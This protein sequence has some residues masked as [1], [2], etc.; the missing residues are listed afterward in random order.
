[1][2]A[3][4]FRLRQPKDSS[5]ESVFGNWVSLGPLPG[6]NTTTSSDH[7]DNRLGFYLGAGA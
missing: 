7:D 4:G 6:W 1:M 5:N 3:G 2:I